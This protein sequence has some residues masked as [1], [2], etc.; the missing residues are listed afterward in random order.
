M[1]NE[2]QSPSVAR[3]LV[4]F[5]FFFTSPWLRDDR[6]MAGQRRTLQRG[7]SANG[8]PL[9]Y[10]HLRGG[11]GLCSGRGS[12]DQCRW[13]ITLV[14]A[15]CTWQAWAGGGWRREG[16]LTWCSGLKGL[17]GRPSHSITQVGA[18]CSNKKHTHDGAQV[19]VSTMKADDS[20]QGQQ[21]C[22][23]KVW[24]ASGTWPLST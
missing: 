5:I 12:T 23:Q 2:T 24:C 18:C 8:P 11:A 21:G 17:S 3:R 10:H 22:D 16:G 20:F 7:G 9:P 15:L 14:L 13:S 6:V 1:G 4:F 19:C